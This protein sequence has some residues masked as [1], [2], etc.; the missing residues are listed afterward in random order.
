MNNDSLP[1]FKYSPNVYDIGVVEFADGICECC[2][3]KVSAYV[4][5]SDSEEW[6]DKKFTGIVEQAGSFING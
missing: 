4:S 2:G 6:K 1:K 5:F 3:K